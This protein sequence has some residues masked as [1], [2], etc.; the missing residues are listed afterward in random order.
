MHR[1]CVL[2]LL[3][4]AA[5]PASAQRMTPD[6]LA[7]IPRPAAQNLSQPDDRLVRPR[8]RP[9][10]GFLAQRAARAERQAA[11]NRNFPGTPLRMTATR[12]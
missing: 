7:G 9:L 12:R 11:F 6:P 1:I 3:A 2:L 10:P 4:L 8:G 5:A